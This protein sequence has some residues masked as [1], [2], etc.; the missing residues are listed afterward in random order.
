MD[1]M[2]HTEVED[3][4]Q[5]AQE[6]LIFA[7][8]LDGSGGC[9]DIP[10]QEVRAW[11][12]GDALTWAHLDYQHETA[13][14][15]LMSDAGLASFTAAALVAE[16]GRPREVREGQGIHIRLRGANLN[17]GATPDDMVAIRMWIEPGRILTTR[18][19]K[20]HP[21]RE[22][23]EDLK[24][25][26]GPTTE[27]GLLTS[28]I[29]KMSLH[30]AEVVDNID[31]LV[32]SLEDQILTEESHALRP[33]I[34]EIRRQIIR[35][36][37]YLAPQREVLSGLQMEQVPWILDADRV[38]LRE[39]N[40]RNLRYIEDLDSARERTVVAGEELSSKLA[41][42][43]NRNMYLLAIVA[44]IFLPLG[45]F[46]GLLGINVGGLP[47]VE[48]PFAFWIVC[49]LLLILAACMVHIFRR[50]KIM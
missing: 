39:W 15:F 18:H 4:S 20:M 1:S 6:G 19:R 48:S 17:P 50:F 26:Q 11:K 12:P 16:D 13:A 31:D 32:D 49:G 44:G 37:R 27:G 23:Y 5:P 24:R 10:W 43:L 41:E 45:L 7:C 25:G 30:I 21:S 28:L 36:R 47:G 42:Q 8:E 35:M 33:Q 3:D 22:V 14:S 38:H 29:G 40:D 34:S 2:R 9:R 46:T